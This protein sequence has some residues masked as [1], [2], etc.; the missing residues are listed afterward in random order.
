MDQPAECRCSE[1]LRVFHSHTALQRVL[2]WNVGRRDLSLWDLDTSCAAISQ[3]QGLGALLSK[4]PFLK[5]TGLPLTWLRQVVAP[6]KAKLAESTAEFEALMAALKVKKAQLKEV[7]DKLAALN[8][9]LQEMEAKKLQ[10]EKDV[11]LC[12]KV[13]GLARFSM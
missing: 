4:I 11:D 2:Y 1:V 5:S 10:L 3:S 7:E 9:Q 13:R 8:S 12:S 6:K